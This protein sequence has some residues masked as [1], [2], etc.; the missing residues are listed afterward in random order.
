M[1]RNEEIKVRGIKMGFWEDKKKKLKEYI[2]MYKAYYSSEGK[3][4]PPP[5]LNELINL[6]SKAGNKIKG[7]KESGFKIPIF[8]RLFIMSLIVGQALFPSLIESFKINLII[9]II[10]IIALIIIAIAVLV[11]SG[12][13]GAVAA[14]GKTPM[15]QQA[16]SIIAQIIIGVIIVIIVISVGQILG[17]GKYSCYELLYRKFGNIGTIFIL[18]WG[19]IAAILA[20]VTDGWRFVAVAIFTSLVFFVL[21][22]IVVAPPPWYYATCSKVPILSGSDYCRSRETFMRLDATKTVQIGG[23]LTLTFGGGRREGEPPQYLTAGEPY[24]FK[25]TLKNFY[26]DTIQFS[27]QPSLIIDY[28]S[29]KL[30]FLTPYTHPRSYLAPGEFDTGEVFFDPEKLTLKLRPEDGCTYSAYLQ[31]MDIRGDV[32]FC[33]NQDNRSKIV[34]CAIDKPCGKNQICV[35]NESFRCD[36]VDWLKASCEGDRASV[37]MS[38][39]HTGVFRGEGT[40]YYYE[41]YWQPIEITE[42]RQGPLYVTPHFLPN[43]FVPKIHEN[44]YNNI[45]FSLRLKNAGSGDIKINS[46]SITPINTRI[47]TIDK[48][49]GMKLEE[50][51]GVQVISCNTSRIEGLILKPGKEIYIPLCFLTLPSISSTLTKLENE[52]EVLVEGNTT[53]SKIKSYCEGKEIYE[54]KLETRVCCA[55]EIEGGNFNYTCV[56]ESCPSNSKQVSCSFCTNCTNCTEP[57]WYGKCD[58]EECKYWSN[59]DECDRECG[60]IY[61]KA[62]EKCENLTSITTAIP[63]QAIQV[64]KEIKSQF[65]SEFCKLLQES[66]TEKNESQVL[67]NSLRFT[68][69]MVE[70]G[71][72]MDF[73]KTDSLRIER[74]TYACL[75][76]TLV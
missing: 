55:S 17:C 34:T 42:I 10:V 36:C 64:G 30:E 58:V 23:G 66:K 22:P 24:A 32:N 72:E 65:G 2:Q 14:A 16:T 6:K 57:M 26:N 62:C 67:Q 29:A 71:Y 7:L 13:G 68:K 37:K 11:I 40:L 45:R 43:P 52:S 69:V 39:H 27:V 25:F 56:K 9:F 76:S 31:C 53:F 18:T 59:K 19:I 8:I 33:K 50:V 21:V 28:G 4:P 63:Q 1:G 47:T 38:V 74:M 75:E 5:G 35:R 46:F 48:S 41:K 3:L 61:G 44:F 60:A 12:G 73:D 20:W 70:L 49:L 54:P 15:G 51:I